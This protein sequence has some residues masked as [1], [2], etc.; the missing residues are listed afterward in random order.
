MCSNR[1][2]TIPPSPNARLIPTAPLGLTSLNL[3]FDPSIHEAA[4]AAAN[5][6]SAVSSYSKFKWGFSDKEKLQALVAKLRQC[7]DNLNVLTASYLSACMHYV[8]S[9]PFSA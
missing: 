1:D 6:D 3:G 4:A 5:F 2:S 7:N 9:P 8:P